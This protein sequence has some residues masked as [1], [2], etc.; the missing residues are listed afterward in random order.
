MARS[1]KVSVGGGKV[2]MELF[3]QTVVVNGHSPRPCKKV[4]PFHLFS[5]AQVPDNLKDDVRN[6]LRIAKQSG[7]K[8]GLINHEIAECLIKKQYQRA[9]QLAKVK[10]AA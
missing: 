9:V 5:N 1:K 10:A 6:Y 3:G 8:Q 7:I 4:K 2:E